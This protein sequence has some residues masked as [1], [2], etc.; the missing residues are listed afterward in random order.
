LA[1]AK[2]KAEAALQTVEAL[3]AKPTKADE[4]PERTSDSEKSK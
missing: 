4:E 3:G 1:K 2:A